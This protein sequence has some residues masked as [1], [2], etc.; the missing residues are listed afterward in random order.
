AFCRLGPSP[1]DGVR[2]EVDPG[3]REPAAGQL[4]GVL[5]CAAAHVENLASELPVVRE[6]EHLRL[7]APDVPGWPALVRLVEPR[8]TGI[9]RDLDRPPAVRHSASTH[10]R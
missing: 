10:S 2:R 4:K 6:T 5:A 8:R 7:R 9:G 1:S 3:D